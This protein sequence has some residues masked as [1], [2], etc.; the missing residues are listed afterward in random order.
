MKVVVLIFGFTLG[1]LLSIA[2]MM[3]GWGL[4]PKSWWWIIGGGI[5]IRLIIEAMMYAGKK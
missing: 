2:I 4:E 1:L 5:G 3:F